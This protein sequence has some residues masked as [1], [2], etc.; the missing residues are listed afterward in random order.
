MKQYVVSVDDID[1]VS[2]VM[3]DLAST[4]AP[5]SP[6]SSDGEYMIALFDESMSGEVESKLNRFG[7]RGILTWSVVR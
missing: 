6:V 2:R 4:G 7:R 3:D 5:M 1:Q